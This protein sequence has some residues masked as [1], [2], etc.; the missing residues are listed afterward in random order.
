MYELWEKAI[1]LSDEHWGDYY[2]S[3]LTLKGELGKRWSS[4][5]LRFDRS[6]AEII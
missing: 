4:G 2:I 3:Y 6:G 1:P 5:V